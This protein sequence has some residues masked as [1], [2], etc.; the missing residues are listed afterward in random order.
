[1]QGWQGPL[2]PPDALRAF[3]DACP[4]SAQSIIAEFKSEAAHRRMQED[5]AARLR[6]RETLFGQIA[7]IV[8]GL[9]ALGVSAFAAF[10]GAEWIGTVVGGGV[11]VS[12]MLALRNTN[13][14]SND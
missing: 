1:M 8:F 14:P 11:I 2:P 5:R 7:A 12:G 3:E 4:G 9:A 10:V 6:V 13:G